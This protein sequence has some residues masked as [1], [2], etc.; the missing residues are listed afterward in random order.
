MIAQWAMD[1][2][3]FVKVPDMTAW[4]S[5]KVLFIFSFLPVYIHVLVDGSPLYSVN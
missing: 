2:E 5:H 1:I 4:I 3:V